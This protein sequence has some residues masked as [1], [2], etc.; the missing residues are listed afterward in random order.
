MKKIL[1]ILIIF[2]GI[3]CTNEEGTVS[4]LQNEGYTDIEV[5]GYSW[6]ACSK[7]DKM[8]TG[9][10]AKNRVGNIVEGTVCEGWFFKNKTIRFK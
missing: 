9:F 8:H 1:I 7:E 10:K 6:F 5:T 3:S 4:L 2:F